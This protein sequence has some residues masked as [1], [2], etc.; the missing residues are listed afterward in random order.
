MKTL[1]ELYGLEKDVNPV[2]VTSLVEWYNRLVDKTV[3]E[4]D[5]YDVTRMVR[6]NTLIEVAVFRAVDLFCSDPFAGEVSDGDLACFLVKHAD[7]VRKSPHF[8]T[9]KKVV[10]EVQATYQEFDWDMEEDREQYSMCLAL[11]NTL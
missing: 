3:D 9:L 5:I 7:I 10:K 6:Q 11:L 1:G 8:E 2:L 4:L